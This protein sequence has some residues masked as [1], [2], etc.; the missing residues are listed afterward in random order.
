MK[1]KPNYHKII[2]ESIPDFKKIKPIKGNTD[3]LATVKSRDVIYIFQ[4]RENSNEISF[5]T[6]ECYING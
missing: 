6:S 4:Y 5:S 3:A 2:N 1:L